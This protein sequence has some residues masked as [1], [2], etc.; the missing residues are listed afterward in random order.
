MNRLLLSILLFTFTLSAGAVLA[1][2]YPAKAV[3]IVVPFPAGGP[4]DTTARLIAP[5]LADS[6]KQSVIVETRAGASG[7]I[8]MTSVAKSEP[9][10]HTILL[11]PISLAIGP[12]LYRKLQF[13][14]VKDFAPVTQIIGTT[15]V[16]VANPRLPAGTLPELIALAKAKPGTLNYGSVGVADPLQL[17]MELLKIQSGVD[18]VSIM[19]KGQA[20]IDT[21]LLAGGG[22]IAVQWPSA[23]PRPL[24]AGRLR[25]LGVTSSKRSPVAPDV[26][27]IAEGGFPGF[28]MTSWQGMFVPA[29]TPRDIVNQIQRETSKAI[30]TPEVRDRI[31][32][33]GQ[34]PVG[35]TPE[36]FETRFKSDVAKFIMIVKEAR[37]PYQD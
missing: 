35:G 30:H 15:L 37:I 9:D 26:P 33:L 28:E 11:T 21:A 10:G 18:I 4:V 34:E 14:P 19:Y 36:E 24:R 2:S 12:A 22:E 7:F 3:R 16:L 25:G 27:T 17:T 20:Q 32:A 5:R 8:G 6:W 1:Q 13:D 23:S 29:R 31:V